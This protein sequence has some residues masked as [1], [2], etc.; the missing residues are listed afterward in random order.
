[1]KAAWKNGESWS[2]DKFI[3]IRHQMFAMDEDVGFPTWITKDE[4]AELSL[5]ISRVLNDDET[6]QFLVW[7]S[8]KLVFMCFPC[9]EEWAG[10]DFDFL[11]SF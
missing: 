11:F 1:M 3:V 9:L 4:F 8:G 5:P 6:D 10:K 2:D 7:Q